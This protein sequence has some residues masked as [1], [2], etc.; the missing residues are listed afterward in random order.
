MV[1]SNPALISIAIG[2]IHIVFSSVLFIGYRGPKPPSQPTPRKVLGLRQQLGDV[3]C[4]Y[5]QTEPV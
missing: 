2:L 5:H 1:T 4:H 3:Q